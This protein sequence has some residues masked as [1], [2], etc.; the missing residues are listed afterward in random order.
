MVAVVKPHGTHLLRER[1]AVLRECSL[2]RA[3]ILYIVFSVLHIAQVHSVLESTVLHV[4]PWQSTL[5]A[6]FMEAGHDN[7]TRRLFSNLQTRCLPL[8]WKLFLK[9]SLIFPREIY[10]LKAE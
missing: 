10:F 2:Y 4:H 5:Y 1:E 6:D 3:S 7:F 8:T 9:L